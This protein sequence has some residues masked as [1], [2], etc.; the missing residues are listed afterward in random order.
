MYETKVLVIGFMQIKLMIFENLII[1]IDFSKL[2]FAPLSFNVY[3]NKN[4]ISEL[5]SNTVLVWFLI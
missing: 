2:K 3:N 1:D 4:K 5:K